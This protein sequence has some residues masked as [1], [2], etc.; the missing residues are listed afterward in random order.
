MHVLHLSELIRSGPCMYCTSL[1]S[2]EAVHSWGKEKDLQNL[3]GLTKKAATMLN[4]VEG[5]DQSGWKK[6]KKLSV[7]VATKTRCSIEAKL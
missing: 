1:N 6:T 7:A 5:P 4:N 3:D 2:L